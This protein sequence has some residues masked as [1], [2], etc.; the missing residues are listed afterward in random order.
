MSCNDAHN[1]FFYLV[2][3]VYLNLVCFIL[4]HVNFRHAGK[5][6]N[7]KLTHSAF[8]KKV[9][10]FVWNVLNSRQALRNQIERRRYFCARSF[11]HSLCAVSMTPSVSERRET[12]LST[13]L[14][15]KLLF[16][17]TFILSKVRPFAFCPGRTHSCNICEPIPSSKRDTSPVLIRQMTSPAKLFLQVFKQIKHTWEITWCINI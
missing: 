7:I 9:F 16:L 3:W 4:R 1:Y 17:S 13:R 10:D 8:G 6:V 14:N 12:L 2:L 15:P 5:K 11:C